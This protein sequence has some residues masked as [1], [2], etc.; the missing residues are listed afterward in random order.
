MKNFI[1]L[2][3]PCFQRFLSYLMYGMRAPPPAVLS[4]DVG[5]DSEPGASRRYA[6]AAIAASTLARA[7]SEAWA[8][9]S[10]QLGEPRY[11]IS[12]T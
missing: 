8:T 5:S 9:S 2:S 10:F 7:N 12:Q 1:T 4:P 11:H 3:F 6:S